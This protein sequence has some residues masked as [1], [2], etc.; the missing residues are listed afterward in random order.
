MD[1]AIMYRCC[2][3]M[4]KTKMNKT[5][6][7][8][9][10]P[11]KSEIILF[12]WLQCNNTIIYCIAFSRSLC[13]SPLTHILSLSRSLHLSVYV[14]IAWCWLYFVYLCGNGIDFAVFNW[15]FLISTSQSVPQTRSKNKHILLHTVTFQW[16]EQS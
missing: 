7:E 8:P 10:M 16:N 11:N 1:E 15:W 12:K 14:R 4:R 9:E 2:R 6:I 3:S 13:A 5:V